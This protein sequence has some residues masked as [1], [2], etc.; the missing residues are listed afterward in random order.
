MR[1]DG[2]RTK[3]REEKGRDEEEVGKRKRGKIVLSP[4][5]G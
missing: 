5:L 1:D 4:G 2:R 3:L